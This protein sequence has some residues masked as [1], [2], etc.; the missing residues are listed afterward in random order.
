MLHFLHTADWH[1]GQ[2]L[3]TVSRQAEHEAVLAEM[4][5]IAVPEKVDCVLAAGDLFHSR[6]PHPDDDRLVI[7]FFA[8][9]LARV[10]PGFFV[11]FV[12]ICKTVVL[13]F[14]I[15][16]QQSAGQPV[17]PKPASCPNTWN[18]TPASSSS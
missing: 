7:G 11:S 8:E 3:G 4:V 10:Y 2:R 9:L 14:G 6:S 15:A 17:S 12:A 18:K 5:D 1:V 16:L 13:K